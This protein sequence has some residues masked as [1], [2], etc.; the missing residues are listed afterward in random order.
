MSYLGGNIDAKQ[1]ST[2]WAAAGLFTN[3]GTH[4][5]GQQNR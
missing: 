2:V 4:Q 1:Q 5:H 3:L